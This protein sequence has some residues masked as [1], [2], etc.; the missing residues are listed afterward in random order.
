MT[1][2]QKKAYIAA[3]LREREHDEKYGTPEKVAEVD[4][5]LARVGF[6]ARSPRQ[7]ATRMTRDA[8]TE[9]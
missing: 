3:L 1:D 2:E 5:E 4:A 6:K 8:G 9:L 7:R